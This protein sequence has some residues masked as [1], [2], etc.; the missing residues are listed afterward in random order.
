[1]HNLIQQAQNQMLQANARVAVMMGQQPDA[2]A[3]QL[4]DVMLNANNVIYQAQIVMG[5]AL[6]QPNRR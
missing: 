2:A 4:Q 1:M 3:Q 6:P 5:Q